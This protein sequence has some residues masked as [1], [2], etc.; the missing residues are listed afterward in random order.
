MNENLP[1]SGIRVLDL[2]RVL[3]GPWCTMSLGDLGAE[4]IKIENPDGGDDTRQW[5]NAL[6]GGERTYFLCANRNKYSIAVDLNTPDGQQIVRDIALTSDVVVEN[7]KLDGLRKFGLDYAT[8]SA[9]NPRIV[10]CSISGYGRTGPA[11]ARPGYDF[12]IQGE[13]GLMSITGEPDGEPMKVGVAL[14]DVMAGMYATQGVLAALMARDKSGQG[15]LIDISLLDCAIANLAN[16]ASTAALQ[17]TVPRRYGNAHSDVV[18]YQ[19]FAASDG[20]LIVAVGND[21]QFQRLCRVVLNRPDLGDD[22]RFRTNDARRLNRDA[23]AAELGSVFALRTREAWL[24]ALLA[25]NVPGGAVKNVVE[26]LTSSEATSRGVVSE[27]PHPTEGTIKLVNSP[28]KLSGTPVVSPR[29]PP[30]LGEHTDWVLREVLGRG[31]R[32]IALLRE[33][34]VVAGRPAAP[35]ETHQGPPIAAAAMQTARAD[36]RDGHQT[37]E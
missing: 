14:C 21:G 34:K 33:K 32:Q 36:L 37:G 26:A 25:A 18:P 29:V 1:L 15:Q 8:L 20:K 23:L 10:Y 4:I 11:A 27:L 31:E 7:Y 30:L 28:L 3:A 35:I 12:V 5:G 19:L 17:A 13:S 9:L 2:T 24:A 22:Q 16:I 6:P